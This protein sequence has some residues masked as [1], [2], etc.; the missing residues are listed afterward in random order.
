MTRDGDAT[1]RE[2]LDDEPRAGPAE[3]DAVEMPWPAVAGLVGLTAQLRR[4]LEELPRQCTLIGNVRRRAAETQAIVAAGRRKGQLLQKLAVEMG[5]PPPWHF[6]VRVTDDLSARYARGELTV[7]EVR[8]I[9]LDLYSPEQVRALKSGW[10]QLP[11]LAVRLPILAEGVE[12]H[13]AGRY[14]SAV[15]TLLPQIEGVLGDELRRK[16]NPQHDGT[17]IFRDTPLGAVAR[18]F[19]VR[20]VH[21]SVGWGPGAAMPDLSRHAILHGRDTG[22]GTEERSLKTI[23]ILDAVIGA[24]REQRDEREVA[25][26][27]DRMMAELGLDRADVE[28]DD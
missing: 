16:P 26:S 22:F 25:A 27:L 11:W 4:T 5:W 2:E 19:Y 24:V 15:C 21:E 13:V 1:D 28:L 14:F 7:D 12:N 9:F 23:L 17:K 3:D 18:D 6:P 20:V 8:R 10:A